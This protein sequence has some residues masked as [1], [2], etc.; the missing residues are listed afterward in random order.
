[1]SD[2]HWHLLFN[3]LPTIGLVFSLIALVIS[4][5]LSNGAMRRLALMLFVITALTAIPAFLTGEPAE[6]MIEP[7]LPEAEAQIERHEDQGKIALWTSLGVGALAL[8]CLYAD[9]KNMAIV[10]TLAFVLLVAGL[11]NVGFMYVVGNSGGEI[12]HTEIRSDA[13]ATVA[14]ALE[15]GNDDHDD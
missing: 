5:A 6:H 1:M 9:Y 3:H 12:R 14:P 7:L 8:F 11:A 15:T 4:L 2:A 13:S 10:K